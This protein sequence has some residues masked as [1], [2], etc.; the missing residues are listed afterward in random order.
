M[1]IRL[2]L[3]IGIFAFFG[4][5]LSFFGYVANN[6]VSSAI[7]RSEMAMLQDLSHIFIRELHGATQPK[8][9][10][11]QLERF[12]SPNLAISV[13]SEKNQV[14]DEISKINM[15]KKLQEYLAADMPF[16]TLHLEAINYSWFTTPL[17]NSAQRLRIVRADPVGLKDTPLF[18]GLGIPLA[19][20]VI[21]VLGAAVW[22]AMYVAALIKN[23][24]TQ[25]EKIEHQALHDN[26]TALPNR[27]LMHDRLQ[28]AMHIAQRD[29]H[30]LALLF[31]DLNNFKS[32][33][34]TL[35]HHNGD[36]LL[37][38]IANRLAA[39]VRKS[40]TLARL[41]SDEFAIVLRNIDLANA[42][43]M[44]HKLT[45]EIERSTEID[46]NRLFVSASIGIALYPEHGDNATT[47]IQCAD[48][49][50]YAAKKSGGNIMV[51]SPGLDAFNREKLILGNDLRSA[52]EQHQLS[53]FYQPKVDIHGKRLIGAEALLRWNHPHF[54]FVPPDKFIA[55]G[56]DAGLMG[57]I[58]ECVLDIA[59]REFGEFIADTSGVTLAVNL[60][61]CSLQSSELT[62]LLISAINKWHIDPTRVILELTES[63]MM[64]DPANA[65][66]V[67]SA[68]SKLGFNISLDDFGTGYSS[69]V[70]LRRLPVQEIKIDRA[71]VMGMQSSEEDAAIVRAIIELG[72]SLDKRVVAEGVETAEIMQAL[73]NLDCDILQ[74]YFI[75]RPLPIEQFKLWKAE[76]NY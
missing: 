15:P 14:S 61:A 5:T 57:A 68:I 21:I 16:G 9:L 45:T 38:E 56:E 73:A 31:I 3:F 7:S 41:G 36:T 43:S 49:A 52:I 37:V 70:N 39:K 40:D 2:K 4:I 42:R 58:T 1:S 66:E 30:H 74:G 33:N 53:V 63:A 11:E 67:L 54:G 71:F 75:S 6:A 48:V 46:G 35:G 12:V 29:K 65:S 59:F 64:A 18:Y 47:L 20:A 25:R 32:I 17:P 44:A 76:G 28:N 69:L 50:M 51:Y 13:L 62:K 34:D 19:L 55:I 60:S 23:L 27:S 72:H 8:L 24:T 10:H 22:S 26:L